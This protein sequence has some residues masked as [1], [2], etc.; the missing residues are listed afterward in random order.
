MSKHDKTMTVITA[1]AQYSGPIPPPDALKKYDT[2]VPG[3]AERLIAMAEKEMEHR[4][5]RERK[6]LKDR[7]S[8]AQSS[9]RYAFASVIVLSLIIG[10]ALYRGYDGAAISVSI[11][12]IASVASLFVY[13]KIRKSNV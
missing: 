4:H 9:I 1:G 7:A 12:A 5:E 13:G 11:A 10:Y 2:I 6:I 3:A 8:L